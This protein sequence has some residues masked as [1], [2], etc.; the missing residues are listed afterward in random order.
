LCYYDR[1][2]EVAGWRKQRTK[3]YRRVHPGPLAGLRQRL[4]KFLFA[5]HQPVAHVAD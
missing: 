5:R 3:E 4:K 1:R 2:I